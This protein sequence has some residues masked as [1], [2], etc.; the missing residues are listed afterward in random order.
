MYTITKTFD[1]CA[2][3]R[4]WVQNLNTNLS[5][6]ADCGC[7]HLHGHNYTLG[8]TL[9]SEELNNQSMVLDYKEMSFIKSVIDKSFDHKFILHRMDPLYGVL[10]PG[11]TNLDW[12]YDIESQTHSLDI[13]HCT[14][15]VMCELYNSYTIVDFVPT[16]ENLARHFHGIISKKLSD[17]DLFFA[18]EVSLNETPKTK[19][20]YN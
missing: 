8:I 19:A 16:S 17:N 1:F 2:G 10:I 18:V 7:R 14:D 4:V 6:S 20:T 5:N 3:H 9:K 11:H 12:R 15:S 13:D